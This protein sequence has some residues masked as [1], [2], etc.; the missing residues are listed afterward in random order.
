M[1]SKEFSSLEIA[2]DSFKTDFTSTIVSLISIPIVNEL[3]D[4]SVGNYFILSQTYGISSTVIY[5]FIRKGRL[6]KCT[7]L[8][9]DEKIAHQLEVNGV[10]QIVTRS[11]YLFGALFLIA[12]DLG[13]SEFDSIILAGISTSSVSAISFGFDWKFKE[14]V[15]ASRLHNYLAKS[16]KEARNFKEY[17]VN[18]INFKFFYLKENF[19]D[20]HF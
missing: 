7:N 8:S 13:F 11:G 3:V 19:K 5:P 10:K 4:N 16:S 18:D 20:W 17:L 15:L 2:I 14:K 6:K 1:N 9:F 12:E